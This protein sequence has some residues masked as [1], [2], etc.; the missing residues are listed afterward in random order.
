MPARRLAADWLISARGEPMRDGALL[1][2]DN[3]R[4]VA[5]GPS[6]AVP[7]PPGI[8]SQHFAG[9]S[10]VPG[11]VNSHTHLELTGFGG[12][13]HEP[14]FADWI[15]RL[16][17]LKAARSPADFLAAARQGVADCF[18][19]GV[20]TVADTGDSGAVIQALAESGASGIAYLEVFGPHPDQCEE[21]LADLQRRAAALR[22]FVTARVSL[23]ISPHAPYSVSGRLFRAASSWARSE[24]LPLAVHIAESADETALLAGAAGAFAGAWARRGI[25]MPTPA[26]D[27]PVA[28]LARHDVLG[29]DLLCIHVVRAGAA[30]VAMIA[31]AGAAVA[32]CP[33]SNAAHAH[34][35]APL[36]AMLG[37]GIRVGC[38]TDSVA[39][40]GTLDLLAEVRAARE[41][42]GLDAAAAF[43]LCTLD[44]ARAIGL[45]REVGSL[46][47]GKWGDAAVIGNRASADPL[48]AVLASAPDDVVGTWV[49]GREAYARAPTLARLLPLPPSPR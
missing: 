14:A 15:G 46:E 48:E 17:Q 10:L 1:I 32:H 5:V 25:P 30:D 27:S 18:A 33:R 16:R 2:G 43:R 19:A 44:A 28:W 21:S 34:G 42:A 36:G 29:P 35:T 23:G 7:A 40:V 41:I 26:G 12:E 20:T 37:A 11:L 8:P 9:A 22:P 49:G 45:E 24:A 31:G 38:G 4:I 6:A 3:G 13:I 39:S 47:P